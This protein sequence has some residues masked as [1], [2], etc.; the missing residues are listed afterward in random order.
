MTPVLQ[1]SMNLLYNLS[2]LTHNNIYNLSSM[3]NYVRKLDFIRG[4][5]ERLDVP[6]NCPL[7]RS[8]EFHH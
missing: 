5:L 1:S 8:D 4:P 2:W 6:L 3:L 7:T